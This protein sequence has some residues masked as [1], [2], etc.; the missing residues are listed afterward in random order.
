MTYNGGM[1]QVPRQGNLKLTVVGGDPPGDKR[2]PSRPHYLAEWADTLGLK[3]VDIVK[4]TGADKGLVSRWFKGTSFGKKYQVRIFSRACQN[5][6]YRW[7][8]MPQI[9]FDKRCK[10][11]HYP[12][13][14]NGG[15]DGGNQV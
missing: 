2:Q 9:M 11:C 6:A 12:S 3:K 5:V 1:R 13:Y 10:W 4:L 8:P 7:Q 14:H 15:R